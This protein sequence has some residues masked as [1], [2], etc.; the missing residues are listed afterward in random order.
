MP[1]IRFTPDGKAVEVEPGTLLIEVAQGQGMG[2]PF[3][4]TQGLCATCLLTV[5]RGMENLSEK[6]EHE[7]QTLETFDARPDQRLG[8]QVKILG[9]V[10]VTYE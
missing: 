7:Q 6:S 1:T 8:C 9:D 5:V 4:C 2:L 3:G 10:I